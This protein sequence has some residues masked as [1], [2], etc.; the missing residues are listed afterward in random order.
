[1]NTVQKIN[2]FHK[3]KKGFLIFGLIEIGLVYVIGSLAINSGSFWE[4]V[5]FMVFLIGAF[6]NFLKL[7][8]KFIHGR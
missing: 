5:L 3:T 7:I 4:W 6:S 1:M 8:G 2:R